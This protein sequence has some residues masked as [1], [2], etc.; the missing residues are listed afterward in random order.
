M[1]PAGLLGAVHRGDLVSRAAGVRGKF[2][3]GGKEAVDAVVGRQRRAPAA[4]ERVGPHQP[5]VLDD[6]E[7]AAGHG[8]AVAV[9]R[10]DHGEEGAARPQVDLA[11]DR[12]P[13]HRAEPFHQMFGNRPGLP[14]Q[15]GRDVDDALQHEVERG[16]YRV[17]AG[18]RSCSFRVS[19]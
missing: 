10:L 3:H 17:A 14:Y 16:V 13:G 7:I 11:F 18:H 6:V 4:G 8:V 2:E 5:A 19:R 9:G 1:G 12:H 15:F